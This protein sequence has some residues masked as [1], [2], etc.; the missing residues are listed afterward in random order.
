MWANW[1]GEILPIEQVKVSVLDRAFLFGD[2][3]YEALRVY[4]GRP[5][6]CRE[7]MERLDRSLRELRITCDV[8]LVHRRMLETLKHSKVQE[9]LIYIQIT[10]GEA[11]RTHAFPKTPTTPNQLIYVKE[12]GG[13]PHAHHRDTGVACVT[14]PDIRWERRDIKSVNLL[15]NCLANQYAVEQGCYEAILVEP[16]GFISEGSHTSVF[17]VKSGKLLTAPCGHHILPGI[18][19][20]LVLRLAK[21]ASIEVEEKAVRKQDLYEV[22]ELFLTGTTT[23]VLAITKVDDKPIGNGLPGPITKRLQETYLES[24]R[25][26][27]ETSPES[28]TD[29][30]EHR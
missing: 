14:Y 1:N 22:D 8:D 26:W 17:A 3:V 20:S 12:L 11:E 16:G 15:G 28:L 9:G 27:L 2:A 19:R 6:L 23:E 25:S 4:S 24:V 29:S 5:W 30:G 13:D 18:T 10:R 7:H 21:T